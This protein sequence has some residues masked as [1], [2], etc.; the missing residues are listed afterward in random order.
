MELYA[1]KPKKYCRLPLNSP[2]PVIIKKN[3]TV[4]KIR[5]TFNGFS[6]VVSD[7]EDMKNIISMGYFG[8]ANFSRS[9]PQFYQESRENIIRKRQLDNRKKY[10]HKTQ[11]PAKVIIA[12]DS[13]SDN[14]EYFTNLAPKYELDYSG[15]KEDV[16]LGLEE[17]FFL[18]SAVHCLDICYKG[19]ILA[20]GDVWARFTQTQSSFRRN[21]VV[22]YYY[23]A[24]NWIVKPGIKFGGDF[25]LYK[26]GPPFFHASYVVIIEVIDANGQRIDSLTNRAM[27][28]VSVLSLNRLCET[29]GKELII[30][31]VKWPQNEEIH[32]SN[33]SNIEIQEILVR[34]WIPSQEREG[35]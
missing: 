33:L 35:T 5:A 19:E 17:A 29:A 9:Y 10:F 3:G 4:K 24:K 7:E 12:P 20:V 14:E 34:R 2:L 28:N 30:C 25:L 21:F 15:L 8:K 16:W 1:P 11:R 27:D 6:V 31:R 32:F 13:D 26:Q 18:T 22:Y 23:K